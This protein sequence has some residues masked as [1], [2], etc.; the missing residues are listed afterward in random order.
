[1]KRHLP[2]IIQGG[3]G[4][5]VSD[6]R[7]A[8]AV[9]S[10]GQLGVVSGVALGA[11]LARRLETGDPGGHMRRA[12][13]AF[14]FKDAAQR[15]L[16]KYFIEGGKDPDARFAVKP[17]AKMKTS[18]KVEELI[19]VANFAEVFLAKEG[20]GNPVGVNFLEKIQVTTLPCLYG[21]MLAGVDYILMGA[22]IPR[23]IPGI[24]DRLAEGF[25]VELKVDVKGLTDEGD[26]F[27]RFSPK[28]FAKD[29]VGRL[30]RPDFLAIVSSHVLARML[31]TKANGEVNGFVVELPVAGGHNAPPRKRGEFS[32]DGEPIYGERDVPDLQAIADLGKPFWLAGGY[33][34][35][36]KVEEAIRDGAVGVQVGTAF[37]Y[38][39]ESGFTREIK[40]EVIEQ[41]RRDALQVYTDAV[42]S[43]TGFPFKVLLLDETLSNERVYEKR[44]RICDLG[45]LRHAY[46]REDATIG[47]RCPSEPVKDYVRKG[48]DIA[49]T[50]GRKCLCNSLIANIGMP[51]IQRNGEVEAT[52]VTSGDDAKG[53]ARFA[54]TGSTSYSAADV[55]DYL[56]EGVFT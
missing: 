37:A 38:C 32:A 11:I 16:D 49:D 56:L 6:W 46:Q 3:M 17:M 48:G 55:I 9:S 31:A 1:M 22:G 23:E 51:Q 29:L 54:P 12:L 35:P 40:D 50:V 7:L 43:P 52:L 15:I 14:P 4:A 27:I 45:Y 41:S 39:N 53:V 24:L 5:A 25:D 36:E 47:W 44:T 21:A 26:P 20:H 10:T 2:V 42:A 13:A 34:E 28:A 18:K 8:N 30:R 19:V 33:G